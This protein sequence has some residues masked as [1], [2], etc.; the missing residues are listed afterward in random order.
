M[1]H[2]DVYARITGR[3]YVEAKNG[4]KP[5]RSLVADNGALTAQYD[6]DVAVAAFEAACRGYKGRCG[7]TTMTTHRFTKP[8]V[9][10][11]GKDLRSTQERALTEACGLDYQVKCQTRRIYITKPRSAILVLWRA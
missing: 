2:R 11:L 10:R 4:K 3:Q 7:V 9:P 8:N 1:M 6:V 5:D